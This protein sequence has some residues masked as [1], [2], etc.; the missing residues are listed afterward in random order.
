MSADKYIMD[1]FRWKAAGEVTCREDKAA[2]LM[3]AQRQ[4]GIKVFIF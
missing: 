3:A 2:A 1:I 4:R